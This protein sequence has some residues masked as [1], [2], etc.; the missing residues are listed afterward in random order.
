MIKF[1]LSCDNSHDFEAWFR[2]NDDFDTQ[3]RRGLLECPVCGSARIG[4][5]LMAPSVSSA[6]RRE[7]MDLANTADMQAKMLQAMREMARHVKANADN[8]GDKF[9]EE[10]RKIHYGE[11]DPR[12]IYGKATPDQ[13]AELAEEGVGFVPLP[14]L[15]DEEELN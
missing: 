14:D 3:A 1:S 6:G 5:S 10:A 2:G 8:V 9:A 13:A 12:G 7:A 15:P 4:K 11:T